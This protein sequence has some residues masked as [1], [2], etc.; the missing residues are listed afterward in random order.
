M[1]CK[2]ASAPSKHNIRAQ[3][4]CSTKCDMTTAL[5]GLVWHPCNLRVCKRS[6]LL[7]I[8]TYLRGSGASERELEALAIYMGH[9]VAMQRGTY[10]RLASS[11]TQI[12]NHTLFSLC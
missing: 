5:K 6:C 9:S 1:Q 2:P 10:D 7:Q 4:T 12:L 3:N 11:P 8:V